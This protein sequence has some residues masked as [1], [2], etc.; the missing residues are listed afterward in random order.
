VKQAGSLVAPDRLRFDFVHHAA[1]TPEALAEIERLVNEQVR[2]NTAVVTEER[3]TQ[4]AM[5]AGAMALF[6]EK[7]GD[8]VRVVSIPGFSMELCGGTHCRATGD[9]GFFTIISEGGVAAGV[10]RVEAL[11]GAAAGASHQAMRTSLNE[12]LAVL[13]TTSDRARESVATLQ[14]ETKRLAGDLSRLKV[15]SARGQQGQLPG[16]VAETQIGASKFVSQQAEN[17]EKGELRQLADA[18]RD[19]IK[20]GVVVIASTSDD[21]VSLVVSVSKDL[22]GRVHAGQIVKQ[23]APIVGGSGGGRPDFAEAGGKDSSRIPEAL[24]ESRRIGEA[25]RAAAGHGLEPVAQRTRKRPG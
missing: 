7:Y 10:R 25:A 1:V 23:I 20:S 16:A 5:A 13:G 3:S 4:E 22:S 19:R 8:R 17:L 18:H 14:A 2:R 9:I 12:V 15:E 6:G 24:A 11:T 21:R